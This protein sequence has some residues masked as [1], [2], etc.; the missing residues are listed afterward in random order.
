MGLTHAH[1]IMD[2]AHA[3]YPR[4][5]SVPVP[6]HP[7]TSLVPRLRPP[8]RHL[9]CWAGPVNEATQY[10]LLPVSHTD[11]E[12]NPCWGW[13]GLGPRLVTVVYGGELSNRDGGAHAMMHVL[14][15][16]ER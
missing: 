1:P 4:T 12:S 13:L 14:S 3:Q 10:G 2:I 9:Q 11:T 5:A 8:Y 7:N 15:V 6:T 16:T